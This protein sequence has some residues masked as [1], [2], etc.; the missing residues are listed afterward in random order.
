MNTTA[1]DYQQ[2]L[3]TVSEITGIGTAQLRSRR[4]TDAIARARFMVWFVMREHFGPVSFQIIGDHA[5][6]DHGT[7]MSGCQQVSD[8]LPF[9][10]ATRKLYLAVCR[11]LAIEPKELPPLPE[12]KTA[13][14]QLRVKILPEQSTQNQ[15]RRTVWPK[16]KPTATTPG[17][18]RTRKRPNVSAVEPEPYR[19]SPAL[20]FL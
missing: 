4:R 18:W 17:K 10:E 3:E 20:N 5:G 8:R 6:K 19:I 16:A 1:T 15:E 14:L 13:P 7:I 12:K 9:E 11:E 2:T